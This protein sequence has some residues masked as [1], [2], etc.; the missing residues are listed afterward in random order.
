VL[1]AG[2]CLT[3]GGKDHLAQPSLCIAALVYAAGMYAFFVTMHVAFKFGV[4]SWF[5]VQTYLF[6]TTAF[7]V[8]CAVGESARRAGARAGIFLVGAGSLCMAAWLLLRWAVNLVAAV[9]LSIIGAIGA[10][11]LILVLTMSRRAPQIALAAVLAACIAS[12][13]TAYRSENDYRRVHVRRYRPKEIATYHAAVRL[14]QIVGNLP[15]RDRPLV[16]WYPGNAGDRNLLSLDSVQSVYLWG[17]TRL[18]N[19]GF[20]PASEP[21]L[22]VPSRKRALETARIVLLG[23]RQSD[24]D[25]MRR[26]LDQA[27]IATRPVR[28]DRFEESGLSCFTLVLDRW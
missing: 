11:T 7:C 22:D 17:Y 21:R 5:F 3:S 9:P 2:V 25:R 24:I 16:F 8:I 4:F 12:P 6:P 23:H 27:G 19:V 1:L 10:L 14:M 13:I 28:S 26:A 20:G 18:A 15:D